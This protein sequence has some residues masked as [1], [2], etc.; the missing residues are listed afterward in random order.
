[1]NKEELKKLLL[2]E[3]DKRSDAMLDAWLEFERNP[4]ARTFRDAENIP[5]HEILKVLDAVTG[6]ITQN[7]IS[8]TENSVE[9]K[10]TEEITVTGKPSSN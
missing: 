1:M 9:L 8:E 4:S 7:A 5:H 3:I 2:E 6:K 10:K